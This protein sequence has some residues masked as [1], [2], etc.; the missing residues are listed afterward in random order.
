[1]KTSVREIFAVAAASY[2]RGNPLLALERPETEAL[3][4][5]VSG[6]AVLDLGAGPG[7]YAALAT[8]LGSRLSIA[9]DLSLEMLGRAP[10]PAVV[11]DAAQ[12]PLRD[13]S[14]DVV[15]AALLLSFV[16]DRRAVLAEA[17]RVLRP[18]G[19][20]VLSDLHPVASERGWSRSFQGLSGERLV[21][22]APP[23]TAAEVAADLA[24]TGF[25]VEVR[26]E[27]VIDERLE[28]EFRRA[29]RRDFESIRGVP[30][31]LLFR[32]RKGSHDAR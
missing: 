5:D 31:L 24:A 19:V 13:A 10:R 26:S 7:H 27:P 17:A 4:P 18:G 11:G 29:G 20:L 2:G 22:D 12:L 23:P 9:F 16:P 32:A 21:I 3:I 28:P 15:V 30:L 1:M 8:A 6:A 25:V 14:V